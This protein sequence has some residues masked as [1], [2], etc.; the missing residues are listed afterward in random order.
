MD[1]EDGGGL[2]DGGL[3]GGAKSGGNGGAYKT[4]VVGTPTPS[5][6]TSESP[7]L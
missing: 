5:T 7:E 6:V 4:T 3:G 2:G 1:D